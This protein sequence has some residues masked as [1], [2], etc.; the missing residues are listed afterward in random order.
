MPDRRS[1]LAV[2][3]AAAFAP[4]AALA[5]PAKPRPALYDLGDARLTIHELDLSPQFLAFYAAAR[6]EPDPDKRYALWKQLYGFA[7]VPPTPQGEAMARKLLDDGWP[8]YQSALAVIRAGA[9]AMKPDALATA[10]KVS[11]A[12]K[13]DRP[14]VIK[15]V[16]YVG[17]FDLNAFS[18]RGGDGVPVVCVPL[19]MTPYVRA[20]IFTHEMTHAVHMEVAHLSGGWERTIAATVLQEGLAMEISRVCVPG[21]DVR[22]YVEA[23]PGWFDACRAEQRAILQGIEP[24]LDRKDSDTVFRFTL[25]T[26]TA[27]L[28]REAYYAGWVV[29]EHLHA[30]GMPW[31]EIARVPEDKMPA[32]AGAAIREILGERG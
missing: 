20:P 24:Y 22:A 17:A 15:V 3:A 19:E 27:G 11:A 29:M 28:Q 30:K 21:R 31:S 12:L 7:A 1:V 9:P 4:A 8:K 2:A 18:Y 6:D 13:A 16:A 14:L 26:G 25:G 10:R 23:T 32:V 5:D